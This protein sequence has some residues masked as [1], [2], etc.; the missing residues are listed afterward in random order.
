M[1]N[2]AIR[3]IR[4]R[5]IISAMEADPWYTLS[6]EELREFI[7]DN[8]RGLLIVEIKQLADLRA[9]ELEAKGGRLDAQDFRQIEDYIEALRNGQSNARFYLSNI[10]RDARWAE[11]LRAQ[12]QVYLDRIE[13]DEQRLAT[14][15]SALLEQWHALSDQQKLF[16]G[17]PRQHI[18]Q[19]LELPVPYKSGELALHY[20]ERSAEQE[21]QLSKLKLV[22]AAIQREGDFGD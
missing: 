4:L 18:A 7:D 3:R 15:L 11:K 20:P 1:S 21:V 2:S 13:R 5:T 9:L 6:E 12:M 10:K 22:L 8:N 16:F 14:E 17:R 19:A